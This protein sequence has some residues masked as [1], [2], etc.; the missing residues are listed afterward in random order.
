MTVAEFISKLQQYD[1]S[2]DVVVLWDG[3][4]C[5]PDDISIIDG[6]LLIDVSDYGTYTRREDLK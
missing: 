6:R 4:L 1:P 2:I 3:D 5:D